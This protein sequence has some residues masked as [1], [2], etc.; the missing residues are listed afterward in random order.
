MRDRT[1]RDYHAR[2]VQ[3]ARLTI[4]VLA[5]LLAC[6]GERDAG[7]RPLNVVVIT[8]DTTRTDALGAD[9]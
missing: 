1:G 6:A 4:L 8:L 3:R 5:A 9:A 2:A 7:P